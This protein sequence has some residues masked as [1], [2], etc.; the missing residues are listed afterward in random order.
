MAAISGKNGKVIQ[1]AVDIVDTLG[2]TLNLIS[3]NPAYASNA[4]AGHK[5]RVVGVADNNG[6]FTYAYQG[7]AAEITQGQA[8]T[9][10]LY[11][12]ATKFW[13]VPAVIDSIAHNTDI[14]DGAIVTLT[15]SFSGTAVATLT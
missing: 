4:T 1:G 6:T 2:W 8:V 12:N 5:T 7:G 9:L 11:L 13:T 10:K 15:A 14:N 3:N